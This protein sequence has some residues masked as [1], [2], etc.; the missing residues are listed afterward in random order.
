LHGGVNL[1][2]NGF[3]GGFV[4]AFLTPIIDAFKKRQSAPMRSPSQPHG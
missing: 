1:Y 2:N 4:A 3:A